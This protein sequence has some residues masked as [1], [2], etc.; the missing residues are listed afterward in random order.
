M[1]E[2]VSV[3]KMTGL[4]EILFFA[5]HN[6]SFCLLHVLLSLSHLSFLHIRTAIE[7][8]N[9]QVLNA[10]TFALKRMKAI[11][12]AFLYRCAKVVPAVGPDTET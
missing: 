6:L 12:H 11:C 2:F 9:D 10:C 5:E 4:G 3:A 1:E 8:L 7:I